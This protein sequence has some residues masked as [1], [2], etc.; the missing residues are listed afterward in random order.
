MAKTRSS[1]VHAYAY[2]LKELKEKKGWNKNKIYTQQECL[3]VSEI[4]K[5]LGLTKPENV[6]QVNEKIFYVIE[7]KNERGKINQALKEAREDYANKINK[8]KLIQAPLVTGIAGN[9]KEGYITKSQY[10]KNGTWKNITENGVDTTGLLSKQQIEKILSSKDSNIKDVEI[11]EEEFLKSAIAINNTLHSN[12]IEKGYRA[13]FISAI[14]LAMSDGKD[15]DVTQETSVLIATINKRVDL[16]LRKHKKQD[17]SRFIK[18]DEPSNEDNHAKHKQAIIKTYQELLGLNIRSAMNSGKD[19]LGKFYEVFLK[20]GNGAK[21]IGIVL[22]PRHITRFAARVLDIQSNDLVYD[23]AC[24]TGGFLVSAFDEARNKTKNKTKFD[25]FTNYGIY[26]VE[27]Q[28]PVIALAIVNM[29]FRGDGKNNMVEGDCFKKFYYA[30]SENNKVFADFEEEESEDRDRPM[31]KVMMNPPFAKKD[32]KDKE[33]KFIEHALNQMQNDGLLFS[34]LPSSAMVK[35]GSYLKWRRDI[36]L[37]DNTLLAVITFPN[38]LFYPVGV[39]TCGIIVKK[40]TPH[41]K[42]QKVLWI[43]VKNDGFVKS[44]GKR[45]PSKKGISELE[46]VIELVKQFCKTLDM[47]IPNVKEFQK[48]C[49]I[50]F[51]DKNLELLAEVYLDEKKPSAEEL[52]KRIDKTIKDILALMIRS[53]KVEEFKSEILSKEKGLFNKKEIPKNTNLKEVPIT[54]LFVTPIKTGHY[55]VSKTIDTG[56]IPLVS[57]VSENGGFEGFIES[58]DTIIVKV[59]DKDK[60]IQVNHKHKIT[61][62]SDGMPLTSFYH[63]YK[64]TAK[65]NVLVCNP[66][67]KYQFTTLLFIVTQLNSLRWRFSYGRKCYENKAHKIYIY[68][69]YKDGKIDEEYISTLFKNSPV[70]TWLQKI[71]ADDTKTTTI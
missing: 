36:L 53:D 61:I 23:P 12:S 9:N 68:L 33:Y 7:A 25:E 52:R 21:E 1:E 13:R 56:N 10:L 51:N 26:G 47:E 58:P 44:K 43:K 28:D 62:A 22:T 30:K 4:K 17:F 40:G 24:G 64:F 46:K 6:V 15:I 57:C 2:I 66:K 63:F 31:T 20:Y 29:I 42:E 32:D 65:D 18:I 11:T 67:E 8:S 69:P 54:D 3:D 37:P 50:D 19:V 27:E 55:H 35:Q 34:V 41:P 71:T 48:A 16:I 38:D 39:E 49:K 59:K 60:T 5:F 14:L 45:L 70:W